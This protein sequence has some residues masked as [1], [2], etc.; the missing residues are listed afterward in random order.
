MVYACL[1]YY[2]LIRHIFGRIP[3]KALRLAAKIAFFTA[4]GALSLAL[5]MVVLGIDAVL[6]EYQTT[7][8]WLGLVTILLWDVLFLM[9]DR[10]LERIPGKRK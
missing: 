6:A 4:V 1:G 2:P 7:G 9:V 3:T 5:T 8:A 10:L